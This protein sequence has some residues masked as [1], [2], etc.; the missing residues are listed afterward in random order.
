[1]LHASVSAATEAF[2]GASGQDRKPRLEPSQIEVSHHHVNL[3]Q[4]LH[5]HNSLHTSSYEEMNM[6]LYLQAMKG[7]IE[8]MKVRS[9]FG[10]FLV[11]VWSFFGR[12]LV[13]F[14]DFWGC[15]H[16][17]LYFSVFLSISRLWSNFFLS[18]FGNF[19]V[20][21]P[22]FIDVRGFGHLLAVFLSFREGFT[23]TPLQKRPTIIYFELPQSEAT[24]ILRV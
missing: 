13:V 5:H 23:K 16:L 22:F 24:K 8:E 1:M 12:I 2:P 6:Q 3:E 20:V 10:Y 14:C 15:V 4:V 17:F 7:S 21:V 19:F 18:L 11:V 9:Y